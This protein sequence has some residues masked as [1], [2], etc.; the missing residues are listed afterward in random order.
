MRKLY[1]IAIAILFSI[2]ACTKI[3]TTN[4][5]SG[6]IPP[7]DGVTTLDTSL[8]IVTNNFIDTTSN[9]LRVYA[10]D[11]HIIGVINNDP[12]LVKLPLK[13]ILS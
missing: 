2:F 4:I 8:G 7:I 12:Y 1:W 9:S 6:L 13:P 3:E 10:S 5:G 11:D